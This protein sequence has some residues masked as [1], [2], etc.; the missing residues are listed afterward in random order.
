MRSRH[1]SA[2]LHLALHSSWCPAAFS[3]GVPQLFSSCS[4]SLSVVHGF[5]PSVYPKQCTRIN[6]P[7]PEH[8]P[9]PSP[10][11]QTTQLGAT[12]MVFLWLPV[13]DVLVLFWSAVWLSTRHFRCAHN[14]RGVP[15][16]GASDQCCWQVLSLYSKLQ[17]LL[18]LYGLADLVCLVCCCPVC[19]SCVRSTC[20]ELLR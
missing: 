12:L 14:G 19:H 5:C 4:C 16:P 17:P 6:A 15:T 11:F 10:G 3:I 2:Q 20:A 8:G 13:M 9:W 18:V 1:A 7:R